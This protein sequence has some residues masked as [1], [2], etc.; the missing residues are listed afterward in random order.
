M[1]S[2]DHWFH[3]ENP[4]LSRIPEFNDPE[5]LARLMSAD[6]LKGIDISALSVTQRIELLVCEKMP[7]EPL[8][9]SIRLAMK[10]LGMLRGSLRY[11]NPRMAEARRRYWEALKGVEDLNT[12][13]LPV[14][15]VPSVSAM[16]IKG[17]TGT[18]KTI[19]VQSVCRLLPQVVNHGPDEQAGWLCASQLVYLCTSFSSDGSRGGFLA[20]ILSDMDRALGTDY[21]TRLPAKHRTVD[22]LAV[23]VV[24]RLIA[25]YTGII[26]IDEGQLR[27]LIRS[28]QAESLQIFL[29]GLMNSG[30]PVVLMGNELAFDWINLSQDHSRLCTVAS[31]RFYPVGAMDGSDSDLDWEA[32]FVGVS[33]Y[34]V[35]SRSIVDLKR[36]SSVLRACS[37]GIQR[38]ALILWCEAQAQ[39]IFYGDDA[40]GPETILEAYNSPSFDD[41]RP[42]AEG[43]ATRDP[44]KLLRYDDVDAEFYSRVWG[45][46]LHPMGGYRDMSPTTVTNRAPLSHGAK[47][48]RRRSGQAKFST[49]KTRKNR[50]HLQRGALKETLS[51]TD[52]RRGGVEQFHIA[53][54]DKLTEDL[55][56]S[57]DVKNGGGEE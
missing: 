47:P 16:I 24:G 52:I 29:L 22:R 9:Q 42:L 39:A 54:L 15:P 12:K 20:Q 32:V 36:C 48:K 5:E 55:K 17:V 19:T 33:R 21:A 23:A 53:G 14:I 50:Q 3:V 4:L 30:I 40:I 37:G 7:F 25:H 1:N 6:L 10:C 38:L 45:V 27:N 51:E 18:G 31:E 28:D 11:R 49:E 2:A 57:A 43:F 35:L 26:F 44:S 56:T 41:L 34:Y 13:L 8:V 46:N